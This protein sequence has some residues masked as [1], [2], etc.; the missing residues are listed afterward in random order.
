MFKFLDHAVELID[1][2][3]LFEDPHLFD[4]VY[5]RASPS[6]HLIL[7]LVIVDLENVL[8]GVVGDARV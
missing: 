1:A 6:K 8:G 2:E 4:E 7:I 3:G 5:F